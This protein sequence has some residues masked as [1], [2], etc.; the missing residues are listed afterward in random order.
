MVIVARLR[1]ICMA[2][3]EANER[4]VARRAALARR[5]GQRVC[6]ARR[7]LPRRPKHL[8]VHLPQPLGAQEALIVGDPDRFYRPLY[9]GAEGLGRVVLDTR[10]DWAMVER[11][12]RVA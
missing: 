9:V 3:P 8:S 4:A 1:K 7:P 12:V 10:P 6:Y 11:L 2:L 5:Q